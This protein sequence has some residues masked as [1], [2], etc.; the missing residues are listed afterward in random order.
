MFAQNL[1][2]SSVPSAG[3]FGTAVRAARRRVGKVTRMN[4]LPM[5]YRLV[6]IINFV[7]TG[8]LRF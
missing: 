6:S 7:W 1:P 3:R 8:Q 5:K 4:V 2:Q